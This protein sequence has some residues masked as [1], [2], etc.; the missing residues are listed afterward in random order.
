MAFSLVLTGSHQKPTTVITTPI[1]GAD[2]GGAMET[3]QVSLSREPVVELAQDVVT[4]E[5]LGARRAPALLVRAG[6]PAQPG[7]LT[8]QG[9]GDHIDPGELLELG[10]PAPGELPHAVPLH[11]LEG[12]HGDGD[13]QGDEVREMGHPLGL[14]AWGGGAD[15]ASA[16][17]AGSFG[18]G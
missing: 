8:G 12:Q 3:Q 5:R 2:N 7:R 9:L 4:A 6:Q 10:D 16:R 11:A 13:Q 18:F 14:P 15:M 1:Q 17:S